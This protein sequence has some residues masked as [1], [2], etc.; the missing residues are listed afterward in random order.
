MEAMAMVVLVM[1]ATAEMAGSAM[2]E[3]V[4]LA[5]ALEIPGNHWRWYKS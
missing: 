5:L 4:E 1:E 2:V 3:M